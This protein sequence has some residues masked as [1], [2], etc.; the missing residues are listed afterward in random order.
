MA[1]RRLYAL[2][3]AGGFGREV[4]SDFMAAASAHAQAAGAADAS[5]VMVE[6]EPSRE[7]VDGVPVISER[8]LLDRR[9]EIRHV[10]VAIADSKAREALETRC[11]EAGVRP[12]TLTSRLANVGPGVELGAGSILCA[13]TTL[14]ADAVIGRSFH[15]NIYSYVAHD[16]VVGDYVTFAPRVS[17]NGGVRIKDHVYVGTGAVIRPSSP[18]RPIV[19][20]AGATIGMGAVVT[21]SVPAGATVVGNPARER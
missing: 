1:D 4:R 13:F 2:F 10:C 6:S 9:D 20:G 19:I 5:F 15:A 14:T 8:E 12:F 7:H 18:D 11:T 21:R 3:G 16:C 17:C